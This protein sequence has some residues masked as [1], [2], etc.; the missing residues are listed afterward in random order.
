MMMKTLFEILDESNEDSKRLRENM[1]VEKAK[2]LEHS[3][4]IA[5]FELNKIIDEMKREIKFR[6]KRVDNGEW[7][8]G[9]YVYRPDGNHSIY[10]KPFDNATR[11]TYHEV[12][13]ETVGQFTG[14]QDK[15]GKDIYEGD[16]G[17]ISS[18][19]VG[20]EEDGFKGV[21]VYLECCFYVDS[22]FNGHNLWSDSYG[23]EIT[24][25]IHDK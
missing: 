17:V 15:N 25:N 22:G 19:M 21:V 10:W 18:E 5:I 14:L 7:V 20:V 8:Y 3:N 24:G 12:T 2:I 16:E 11:N 13:P 1:T 9:F 23:F 4:H 6:G